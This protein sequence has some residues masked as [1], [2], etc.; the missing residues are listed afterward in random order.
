MGHAAY[1]RGS[2]LIS[3]QFQADRHPVVFEVMGRL[4][5]HPKNPKAQTPFGSILF[6]FSHGVWW[7]ECPTTGFGYHYPTIKEAVQNW[8]VTIVE[9][10]AEDCS[11]LAEPNH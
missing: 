2:K 5:A 7:A 1:I 11:W 6:V 3:R 10:R 4:N 8:N 9:H